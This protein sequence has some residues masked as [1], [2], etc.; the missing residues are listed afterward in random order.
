MFIMYSKNPCPWCTKAKALLKDCGLKYE[1]YILGVDYQKSDL[2]A[3]L[4][5]NTRLTVPQVF[6]YNKRIGG[7]EDLAEYLENHGMMGIKQ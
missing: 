4:P 6:L 7:Y 2:E 1:E 5:P 3:L